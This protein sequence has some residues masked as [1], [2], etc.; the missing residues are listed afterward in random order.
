MAEKSYGS[1]AFGEWIE[2]PFGLPAYRYTCD[3]TRDPRVVTPVN[4]VWR[5]P[6]EHSHQV[7]N[8]RLVAVASNDGYV[9]VRQDEGGPKFLNDYGPAHNHYRRRLWLPDRWDNRT[10][11]ILTRR[12]PAPRRGGPIL[13][14]ASLA[15]GYLRK[16]VQRRWAVRRPGH[17]CAVWR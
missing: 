17:L 3:Q 16:T 5:G 9:Q 11:H 7:G 15:M 4:P 1:G 14:A 8:D 6:T 12:R 2:D 10:E 13:R